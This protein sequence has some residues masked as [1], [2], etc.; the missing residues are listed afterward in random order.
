MGRS[1]MLVT[2]VLKNLFPAMRQTL[3]QSLSQIPV[4]YATLNQTFHLD[5][6][7]GFNFLVL[8]CCPQHTHTHTNMGTL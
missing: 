3:K 6:P 1:F 7:A 5:K 4:K 2:T 8:K